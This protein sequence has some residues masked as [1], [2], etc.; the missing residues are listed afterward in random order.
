VKKFLFKPV[1]KVMNARQEQVDKIY[2]DAKDDR[3]AASSMKQE[4]EARLAAARDEAEGDE[5][6]GGGEG[7]DQSAQDDEQQILDGA[8]SVPPKLQLWHG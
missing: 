1:V 8:F 3:A 2:S 7:E 5:K 6:D 4:Y